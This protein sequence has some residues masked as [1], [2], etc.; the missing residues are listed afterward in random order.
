MKVQVIKR[1]T[2]LLE[3]EY[4]RTKMK[5]RD[6]LNFCAVKLNQ[7]PKSV[8]LGKIAARGSSPHR[9]NKPGN[10]DKI[11]AFPS[12]DDY[13]TRGKSSSLTLSSSLPL[14]LPLSL[15]FSLGMTSEEKGKSI[16]WH[17][18]EEQACI[19]KFDFRERLM[20]YCSNDVTVLRLC[21]LKLRESFTELCNI[22]PFTCVTIASAYQKYYRTY[23]LEDDTI[24][25][26]SQ[27]GYNG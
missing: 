3:I 1:G 6:S 9:M 12:P 13:D 11:I 26:I 19:G 22:D 14:P 16:Q 24:A 10:W 8:G 5:S 21:A 17:G 23:L 7:F 25:V 4:A 20:A 27:H 15:S 2:Q 18:K